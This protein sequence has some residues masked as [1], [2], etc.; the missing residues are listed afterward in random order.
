MRAMG[1]GLSAPLA[2]KMSRLALADAGGRPKRLLV[3]FV[4][5]GMPAEHY[6]P[7]GQG[8]S[9][10][11]A[12]NPKFGVLKVFKPYQNQTIVLR[13]VEYTGRTQHQTIAAVLTGETAMS[14]DQVVGKGIGHTPLLLGANAFL[15]DQF[16]P[17]N[18]MFKNTEWLAPELNP[19]KAAD[20]A[21]RGGTG[22]PTTPMS[23]SD[24]EFEQAALG[25]GIGEIEAMQKEL[26]SLTTSQSRLSVHLESLKARRARRQPTMMTGGTPP[27]GCGMAALPNLEAVKS[28]SGGGATAAYFYDKTNFKAL[29]LAQLEVARQSLIC[30]T[31]VV[32]LQAMWASGQINFGFMGVNKDHHDPI[33]HSRDAAGR[34]EFAK[35]QHWIYSQLEEFVL[36]PLRATP[37]P[38][39]AGR[40]V[41]DNTLVYICSE[42][43]DGNEHNC[44][45]QIMEL[46][47][48]KVTTQLPLVLIGGGGG[49]LNTGQVV[50]YE[51]RTH[52]DLLAAIC[53]AMGTSGANFSAN[54]MKEILS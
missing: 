20:L 26:T 23:M 48:E 9:F 37:D 54:P 36:R 7:G 34:E 14:V 29:F 40:N 3:F 53:M 38:L 1:L 12:A 52:K 35:V 4:P 28:A 8:K 49:A 33:S 43:A 27:A 15:K 50:D 21:L 16:G 25:L 17:D 42:I 5:H 13:G 46:G 32:G 6:D 47:A 30:G 51:N 2:M 41:L 45:K 39:D 31:R 44:R 19:V 18:N 24:A 22:T 11:L 10:D